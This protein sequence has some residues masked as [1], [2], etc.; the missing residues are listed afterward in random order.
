MTQE[1][2]TARGGPLPV[3]GPRDPRPVMVVVYARTRPGKEAEAKR[4]L[5]AIADPIRGN[6]DCLEYHVH[7]DRREPESFVFY[8]IWVSEEAFEAHLDRRYMDHYKTRV[9]DLF[10]SRNWHYMQEVHRIENAD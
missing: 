7:Q 5:M 8:E 4:E 6:P 2:S 3:E 1:S 10:E 9:D